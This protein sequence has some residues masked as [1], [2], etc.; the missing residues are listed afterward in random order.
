MGLRHDPEAAFESLYERHAR[1]VYGYAL[2]MLGTPADAEDVT[3]TTFMNAYRAFQQGRLPRRPRS[4]LFAIAHN[5]CRQR[6]RQA[7]SRPRE[8]ELDEGVAE[9]PETEA[10]SAQDIAR[11]LQSLPFNQRSALVMRELEGRKQ[12]EIAEALEISVSAVETLLFRARRGVREQ[13]ENS[14]SC[15]E[16]GRAISR[17]L[18]GGSSRA[19]RAA[20]RAHLRTCVACATF[21]RRTRAER[22]ALRRLRAL[23]LPASLL[24]WGGTTVGAPAVSGIG[25]KLLAGAAV[26][27]VATGA[28]DR[29]VA[30][31]HPAPA[32]AEKRPAK[33]AAAVAPVATP[34]ATAGAE[35]VIASEAKPVKARR[36]DTATRVPAGHAKHAKPGHAKKARSVPPGLAKPA[37]PVPPGLTKKASPVPPGHA[38]VKVKRVPPR[39]ATARTERVPPRH[40]TARAERVPTGQS[41]P[42]RGNR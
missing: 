2:A 32:A 4:W 12:T 13:L 18:D 42:K 6:W 31:P 35:P 7:A 11:A 30:R 21:A 14:L 29:P 5:V 17:Q 23:P 25:L 16:A 15:D 38:K 19:E 1:D 27:A 10:P 41:K 33:A 28:G 22:G 34:I 9:A 20:L 26:I 3:Q 37:R 8:V 39:H 36:R 24:T 40:P